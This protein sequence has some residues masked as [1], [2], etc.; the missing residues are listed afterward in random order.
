I[1]KAEQDIDEIIGLAHNEHILPSSN[2]L[3][4]QVINRKDELKYLSAHDIKDSLFALAH[5]LKSMLEATEP[6]GPLHAKLLKVLNH[7]R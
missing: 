7:K 6:K 4:K 1:Q 5:S 2:P 3:L